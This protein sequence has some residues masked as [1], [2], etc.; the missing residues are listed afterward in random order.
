MMLPSSRRRR[1]SA[2]G[3]SIRLNQEWGRHFTIQ[4]LKDQ[5]FHAVF[6]GIGAC[7]DEP[8]EIPCSQKPE[9]YQATQFLRLVNEGKKLKLG[10]RAAV[11]GGNNIAMEVARSLLRLG[12]HDVTIIYPR[13]KIE[14]PAHQ[15]NIREAEN[16]GV[17]FLL[18]ASPI[19]I[20]GPS[21]TET[22]LRLDLIRMK[23]GEPDSRGRREPIPI[24]GAKNTLYVDTIV[25]SLGQKSFRDQLQG[26]EIEARL[27]LAERGAIVANPRTSLTN[28]EGVFAGG[29]AVSGPKSVIQAVV[30]ARRAAENMHA[31]VLGSDKEILENRFNFT[32]GKTFDEVDLKNFEGI[33]VTLREK[34]P[35]RPP[36]TALQDFDEVRLGYTEK[37][38]RREALRCLSCGCNAYDRC[39]L[40]RLDIEHDVN[41]LKTG[42]GT[43]PRYKIDNSHPAIV[44]DPNKCIFCGR[45]ERYCEYDALELR[46]KK[47]NENGQ[48][49][50]LEIIFKN[51][52][53]SCGLCVENCPTGALN[54]KNRIVPIQAEEVRTVRSTCPYCGTGCQIELKVKGDTLMEIGANPGHPPNF[55]DLCV[56][57]RFGHNFVHHPDRLR[58]PLI[59]RARSGSLEPASWAEAMDVIATAFRRILEDKGADALAGMASARCTNEENYAFQKFFRAGIGTNN[60]DHC[61]RY[62]H[63]PSVAGLTSVFGSGAMSNDIAGIVDNKALLVIGS[64]TGEAHPV[65]ALRMQEAVRR[66]AKLIVADPRHISLADHAEVW[67]R[68]RPGTDG[69]LINGL[70]HV[71]V[72]DNLTDKAFIAE[73]TEGFAAFAEAVARCTPNWTEE[74]TG[75]PAS[76]IEAAARI[77]AEAECAGIYYT[78]G[79]TQHT[80]G[81]NNVMALAN[82]ALLTGN[83][84]KPGAGLNPLRGQNN[85]QGASDMGCNPLNMPGYQ[86]VDNE[87]ARISIG[88]IW[89]QAPKAQPGLTA[90][91]M[92]HAML[93]G[94]I[95]GMWIMGENPMLSDPNMNLV[96][97]ALD[98]LDFLLVQDIFLTETAELADVVLPAASFAEKDG[99]FTNTERRVQRVR[100]AVRPPGEAR[101]DLTIINLVTARMGYDYIVPLTKGYTYRLYNEGGFVT[102]P[103]LSDEIFA[104]I[105]RVVP[106]MAGIT[107]A[108]LEGDGIQWPCPDEN[109]PGTPI[110]FKNGFPIGRAKFTPVAWQGPSELPDGVYPMVLSTGRV[111]AQYHTGTMSRRSPIL[112]DVD[113]GPYAEINPED[114]E[115]L[116]ISTGETVRAVS[117]RGHIT[118]PALVTDRVGR[119]LVFIPFHYREAAAN[120]LTNDALDPVCKIPEAKVCAVRLEKI[121]EA[122][123]P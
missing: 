24:P 92:I 111:L 75:V 3:L 95:C 88:E 46:A 66:G 62:C 39:D 37:M 44:V 80:T 26:G 105:G 78:M 40:K 14:M 73:Q 54:K 102:A 43:I 100:R 49:L 82:L 71:I 7:F 51:N 10:Q 96:R 67:L 25:S 122:R 112:E 38:A 50:G 6:I 30:S 123:K 119:G 31:Y 19:E 55:G 16:E 41:I 28:V 116:G 70:C 87:E 84:G 64:N 8:L 63:S 2:V 42:M 121:G 61:A 58:T 120:L 23:L 65:I 12:V 91:E 21:T 17:K 20:C 57:G 110:L 114:A 33:N 18:M 107:Y 69:A 72:R 101:D 115:R 27:E 11:I 85:V 36:E 86:R 47:I 94:R 118:I 15:R 13:A 4:D 52:C 104:E 34:M 98:K 35:D 90:T 22:R 45:C 83:L 1:S 79:I 103:P 77:F 117:R 53:V 81:T 108:R 9:V 74:I 106:A 99:T 109:H 76:D 113:K 93:E 89:G 59:R 56:K 29:D 60:I 5:G 32:R 48:P 97:E 68:H